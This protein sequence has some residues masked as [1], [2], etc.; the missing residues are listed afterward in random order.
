MILVTMCEAERVLKCLIDCKP[1]TL[2]WNDVS[3]HNLSPQYQWNILY[4]M[5]THKVHKVLK[6]QLRYNLPH[7]CSLAKK[8]KS[9]I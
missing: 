9:V 2:C 4:S 3:H 7:V 8:K 5:A 1:I 6:G